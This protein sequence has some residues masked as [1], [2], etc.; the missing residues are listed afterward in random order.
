MGVMRIVHVCQYFFPWLGYQEY[1]L[2]REQIVLGHD[3]TVVTSNFRWPPIGNYR[4]LA[5]SRE[6]HLMATGHR[7]ECG[8][9]CVRL[10]VSW[11]PLGRLVLRGLGTWIEKLRPDVVLAHGYLLPHTFMLAAI[12]RRLGF[13]LIVDEHQLPSQ[14]VPGR[15]H[16]LLRRGTARIAARAIL[17]RASY[18]VA[19][20]LGTIDWLTEE[21]GVPRD[22]IH[23][24]PLGVS[25]EVFAPD[26]ERGAG[27][28]RELGIRADEFVIV[29]SGK[30]APYKRIDVL[31]EALAKLQGESRP[32]ITVIVGKGDQAYVEWVRRT[33]FERGL[34]GVVHDGVPPN[35]L[36]QFFNA[37][38]VCVWPA[39]CTISHLEAAAC[40]KPIIVPADRG[41]SDRIESGNGL[42]V[43]TGDSDALSHAIARLY[44]DSALRREMGE[45]GLR[46]I[47]ERYTWRAVAGAFDGLCRSPV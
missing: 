26:A 22:R 27:L 11:Q 30:I 38:D 33:V 47:R 41:I 6:D 2:A 21:Y 16:R 46:M 9:P 5:D 3:V 43:R 39:D 23:W 15:L 17:P 31:I 8:V 18:V 29:Y 10:P 13:K 19:V 1:Y 20:A 34:R 44:D 40:G 25:E 24:I 35:R 32:A 14:S 4:V 42:A 37:A 28:R 12:Q 45:K 7:V 36:A